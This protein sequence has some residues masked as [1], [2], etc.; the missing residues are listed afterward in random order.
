MNVWRS[1]RSTGDRLY[2]VDVPQRYEVM[3]G[4]PEIIDS[5]IVVPDAPGLGVD[6]VEDAIARY[7]ATGNVSLPEDTYDYQYVAARTGRARWLSKTPV[8]PP[9]YS[10]GQIY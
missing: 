4:Q 5:H 2:E 10:P 9:G 1:T 3:T 8:P 6:L 7:L